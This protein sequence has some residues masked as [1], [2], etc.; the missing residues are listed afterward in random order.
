M[1][2]KTLKL[3]PVTGRELASYMD[4]KLVTLSDTA[5][6]CELL[7]ITDTVTEVSDGCLF[8]VSEDNS[9]AEM[10]AASK[11]APNAYCARKHLYPLKKFPM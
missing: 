4:A 5:P 10:M 3:G 6:L 11:T 9:L 7:M 1:I 8:L 2:K